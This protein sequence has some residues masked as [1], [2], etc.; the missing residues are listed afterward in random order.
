MFALLELLKVI[1]EE[2]SLMN[3]IQ[4]FKIVLF[5]SLMKLII[6]MYLLER[7]LLL[8]KKLRKDKVQFSLL[9]NSYYHLIM[10]LIL[11]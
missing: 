6:I 10:T 9:L 2:V 5:Y 7:E 3:N 1:P 8:E 4:K 11:N